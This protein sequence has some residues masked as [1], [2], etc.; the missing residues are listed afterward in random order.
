LPN[1]A[2]HPDGMTTDDSHAALVHAL[3]I[4]VSLWERIEEGGSG[5]W[6]LRAANGAADTVVALPLRQRIGERLE[7]IFVTDAGGD[8]LACSKARGHSATDRAWLV[9]AVRLA[10]ERAALLFEGPT[11]D[12]HPTDLAFSTVSFQALLERAFDGIFVRRE[13]KLVYLN[14]ALLSLLGYEHAD[15]LI[16]RS[17][18]TF[19]HPD[20]HGLL[21]QRIRSTDRGQG[22]EPPIC[23]HCVRKDGKSVWLDGAGMPAKYQNEWAYMVLVRDVTARREEELALRM[24]RETLGAR[25]D[26]KEQELERARRTVQAEA[27]MRKR[28]EEDLRQAQKMDAVGRLAGGVAHDFNNLLSVILAHSS[29]LARS[30]EPEDPRSTSAREVLAAGQ[31]AADLT[32]QLLALSRRQVLEPRLVDVNAVVER[33][34]SMLARLVGEHIEISRQLAPDI[35][36]VRLDPTQ[37]EQVILNLVVNARDAMPLGGELA[38]STANHIIDADVARG[39]GL[40]AGVHVLLRVSDTGTGMNDET[41]AH[42]FEPFFTTKELVNSIGLGLSTARDIVLS[43]GG[44]IHVES[45]P[46][47]GAR[48]F[49]YLPAAGARVHVGEHSV[50]GVAETGSETIAVAED[51][52]AVR[53]VICE[54]LSGAGYR[55]LA[56]ANGA[57]VLRAVQGFEGTVHLLMSDLVMPGMTGLELAQALALRQRNIRV[58]I[59]SG[60]SK[61]N[62]LPASMHFLPKPFT[63]AELLSKVR[64]VLDVPEPLHAEGSDA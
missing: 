14:P 43:S 25:L 51:E 37:L 39:L 54:L 52:P 36:A 42:I 16:G 12:S 34:L 19:I 4:P 23:V 15:E 44:A 21:M 5:S 31:R 9:R 62:Q 11:D 46:G 38:I 49:V 28:A 35:Q 1:A 48:F 47:A 6:V 63:E 55:V 53:A 18:L 3:P 10:E 7:Q 20:H 40:R 60:Y 33:M 26:V 59:V 45:A 13:D 17:V 56:G 29:V 30:L 58:L 32:R 57:E 64:E 24:T 41:R 22:S 61:H 2:E 27:E 8:A 50:L